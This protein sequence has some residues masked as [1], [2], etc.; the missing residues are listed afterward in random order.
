MRQTPSP[1]QSSVSPSANGVGRHEGPSPWKRAAPQGLAAPVPSPLPGRRAHLRRRPGQGVGL[2]GAGLAEGEDSAGEA[3]GGRGAAGPG[4]RWAGGWR[5]GGG[6]GSR[7]AGGRDRGPWR[8]LTHP[9]S[10]S[11]PSRRTPHAR[12]T[13]SCV[14]APSSTAPKRNATSGPPPGGLTWGRGWPRGRGT[15]GA[16][17]GK[18]GLTGKSRGGGGLGQSCPGKGAEGPS[19]RFVGEGLGLEGGRVPH[20]Q[21]PG[22]RAVQRAL[23]PSTQLGRAHGTHPGVRWEGGRSIPLSPSVLSS[24]APPA[25]HSPASL[26]LPEHHLDGRFWP[27]WPLL[28]APCGVPVAA[29]GVT[30]PEPRGSSKPPRISA[31]PSGDPRSSMS[32][33]A[34]EVSSARVSFLSP[35]TTRPFPPHRDCCT[36][37]TSP[38]PFPPSQAII[39]PERLQ[40]PLG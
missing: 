28:Q 37:L 39:H 30:I 26:Y 19:G 8:R 31:Y 11:S 34:R 22:P 23:F 3:A 5:G 2:P 38:T 40:P 6:L 13:S 15:L 29:T 1:L 9:R 32:R 35:S 36:Q 10:A 12:N 16:E 14:R 21:S 27:L 33:F 4:R 17:P 7:V 18:A 25:R 24:L 20:L